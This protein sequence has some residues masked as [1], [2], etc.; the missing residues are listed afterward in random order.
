MIDSPSAYYFAIA[1][2]AIG[3]WLS[4]PQTGAVR[5]RR[6]FGKVLA[7]AGLLLMLWQLSPGAGRASAGASGV[8]MGAVLLIIS[9]GL[10]TA[11]AAAVVAERLRHAAICFCLA[12]LAA[13]GLLMLAAAWATALV[14]ATL[15]AVACVVA[16]RLFSPTD[17]PAIAD[18]REAASWEPMLA[19]ATAAVI[20]GIMSTIVAHGHVIV[21]LVVF[22][23]GLMGLISRQTDKRLFLSAGIM[24]IGALSTAFG[25]S[26][27]AG[28]F[29]DGSAAAA[30]AVVGG[31]WIATGFRLVR[32]RAS[33]EKCPPNESN[34]TE[35]NTTESNAAEQPEPLDARYYSLLAALAVVVLIGVLRLGG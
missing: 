25:W 31:V 33:C 29:V 14:V 8:A 27:F 6:T 35:S 24:L 23:I 11:A 4:S 10:I 34:A 28:R 18:G 20:V 1:L 19:A 5:H 2:G 30:I 9:G 26:R 17:R 13:Y 3:M 7:A 32:P 22:G 12:V 15:L 21:G 16:R